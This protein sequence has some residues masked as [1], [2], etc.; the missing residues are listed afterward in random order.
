MIA[1]QQGTRV[2]TYSALTKQFTADLSPPYSTRQ[3]PGPSQSLPRGRHVCKPS[4]PWPRPCVAGN[5]APSPCSG[6]GPFSERRSTDCSGTSDRAWCCCLLSGLSQGLLRHDKVQ[7]FPGEYQN[8]R[9][10]DVLLEERRNSSA[11]HRCNVSTYYIPAYLP[12]WAKTGPQSDRFRLCPGTIYGIFTR[13]VIPMDTR[14]NNNVIITSK[15]RRG[16]VLT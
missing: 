1:T 7:G 3:F 13:I 15:R 6:W 14:P 8:Q 9:H 10:A 11:F 4:S 12:L 16:V 2:V 5:D